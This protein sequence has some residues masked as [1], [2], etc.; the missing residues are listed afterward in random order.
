MEISSKNVLSFLGGY[1]ENTA[2]LGMSFIGAHFP[3]SRLHSAI[4]S[5]QFGR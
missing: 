3:D 4:F 2:Q 5:M 1:N